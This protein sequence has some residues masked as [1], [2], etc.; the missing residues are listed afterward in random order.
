M[1]PTVPSFWL[2]DLLYSI[3]ARSQIRSSHRDQLIY[4][5]IF[6]WIMSWWLVYDYV[7]VRIYNSF[8]VFFKEDHLQ[9]VDT[10]IIILTSLFVSS[11]MLVGCGAKND[12]LCRSSQIHE[13]DVGFYC[14]KIDLTNTRDFVYTIESTGMLAWLLWA[15]YIHFLVVIV[16]DY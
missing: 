15:D 8:M 12:C 5:N 3:N 1:L 2:I 14:F 9:L 16:E 7:G 10:C 13:G 11:L 4:V 6:M